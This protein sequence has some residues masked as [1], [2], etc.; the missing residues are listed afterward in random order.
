MTVKTSVTMDFAL[1]AAI[2]PVTYHDITILKLNM[3][4][5]ITIVVVWS[6]PRPLTMDTCDAYWEI[7]YIRKASSIKSC[8]SGSP[9]PPQITKNNNKR[10]KI[11]LQRVLSNY[12]G[13]IQTKALSSSDKN[14]MRRYMRNYRKQNQRCLTAVLQN[15]YS[16]NKKL[17]TLSQRY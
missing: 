6:S 7:S 16:K 15:N 4:C 14:F 1:Y 12:I 9:P 13:G 8:F 2:F 10:Q 5:F 11:Q 17:T 3:L